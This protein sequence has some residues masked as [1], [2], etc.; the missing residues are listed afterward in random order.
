MPD[1][2]KGKRWS[3]TV[4]TPPHTVRVYERGVGGV[5]YAATWDPSARGGK[6]GE[7]RVSLKH[8][9]KQRALEWAEDQAREL[10]EGTD[11]L[12]GDRPTLKRVL[13]FYRRHRSPDKS[14]AV[15]KEDERMAEMFRRVMGDDFDL[16]HL[17]RREWDGFIRQRRSGAI[18]PRGRPVP[19]DAP[20]PRCKAEDPTCE[21]CEGTGR[22]NPRKPVSDRTVERD[23]RLLRA[24]CRWAC[25]FRTDDGRLLLREDPTRGRE[26]PKEKNPSRPVASHDRVDAIREVYRQV[27][28][29]VQREGE[30]QEVESY[31]P[32]IFEIVVGTG[33]RISAVCSLLMEDLELDR[34]PKTP[35][36]AICWPEDTDKEGRRW[37]CPISKPVREALEAAEWKR[38][39]QGIVGPGPL[40]PA[41]GTP[42]QPVRY[43]EAGAW[44]RKAEEL[45]GLEPHDGSLWHAYRRLW[46][47]ARKDLPDVDVAQA[48]GWSSLE[49]LK[50]A[51][52]QPDDE[53]MLRVVEHGGELREVR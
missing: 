36:G 22:I 16:R 46:A 31:L 49:A 32:E 7:R 2:R 10:K 52:Q 26:I 3:R 9:D 47:S 28:M 41:P 27:T 39:R 18:D 6:G 34:A 15:Q 33:R 8:R 1:Q 21:R 38:R 23:L 35:H 11:E 24:V 37:R 50:L 42:K 29:R 12:R 43:Q 13:S 19:E 25:D 5:L 45:A 44:L 20:C 17:S 51:Y 53:T 4:G 30:R 14:E 48:G 40:F